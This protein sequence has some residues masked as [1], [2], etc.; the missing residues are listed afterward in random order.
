MT[1]TF[2]LQVAYTQQFFSCQNSSPLHCPLNMMKKTKAEEAFNRVNFANGNGVGGKLMKGIILAGGKGTRLH[3]LTKVCNKHLLPVGSFPMIYYSIF[4]LRQAGICDMMIVTG[5]EDLGGFSN[6]LGSG[7]DFDVHITYRVQEAAGGIAEA[8]FL[9]KDFVGTSPFVALLGDNLFED[10]LSNMVREFASGK[11]K[12]KLILKE[13]DDPRQF[14]VA[15]LRGKRIA[16]IEEKPVTPKSHLA[17]TGIYMYRPDVFRVIANLTP[18]PRGEMEITDVNNYYVSTGEISYDVFTGWWI[19][20][21]T[22]H[23]YY[24]ANQLLHSSNFLSN[25]IAKSP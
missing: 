13:V 24:E 11:E 10:D 15:E 5:K 12:A 9:A 17:V 1:P 16:G 6:L 3:P 2:R 14:G 8:L 23:S 21:G 4:K 25:S 18:S 20:A 19:D 7:R 22:L